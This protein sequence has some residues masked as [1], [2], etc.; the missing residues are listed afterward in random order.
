M[1]LG[2]IV[3]AVGT[4]LS[5]T[6]AP[7]T[8]VV[9]TWMSFFVLTIAAERLELSRLAPTPRSAR[10][11]FAI[12]AALLA[13]GSLGAALFGP[14]TALARV[15]GVALAAI[16][17]WQLR[18]D[19]A[20]RVLKRPGLPAFAAAGVLAGAFWLV[21]A[22]ALTMLFGVPPGGPIYD[23]ILHSVFVGYV[24]SMV[25]AHAAIVLPAV[26]RIEIPFTKYLY[27]P[28]GAL[29][30]GLSLRVAGDLAG[31]LLPRRLGAV[32]TAVA[33]IVFALTVVAAKA[34]RSLQSR[35]TPQSTCWNWRARLSRRTARRS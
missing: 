19:L 18:F 11:G 5:A 8:R 14:S 30:A 9:L 25:F 27:L 12:A 15:S 20:R 31:P 34:I 1:L 32:L 22:G 26:A 35:S 7:V 23:A 29:H 24:L 6:G 4:L 28:L 33:L 3:L 17:L 10:I 13:L 16:G 2:S 21:V